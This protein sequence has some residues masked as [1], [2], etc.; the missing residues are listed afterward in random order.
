[1][2]AHLAVAQSAL[3]YDL[4]KTW[5]PIS[6]ATPQKSGFSIRTRTNASRHDSRQEP[7]SVIL[8]ARLRAG[9]TRGNPRPYHDL[10]ELLLSGNL[11]MFSLATTAVFI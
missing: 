10:I 3:A 9:G 8:H 1:M 7:H 2:A 11:L 5:P 4:E 6:I